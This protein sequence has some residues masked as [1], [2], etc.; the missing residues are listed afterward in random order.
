MCE[1]ER[2]RL[3]ERERN[4]QTDRQTDRQRGRGRDR[5]RHRQRDRE[6]QVIEMLDL[7]LNAFCDRQTDRERQGGWERERDRQTD[8]LTDRLTDTQTLRNHPARAGRQTAE[9]PIRQTTQL[10]TPEMAH[11][12]TVMLVLSFHLVRIRSNTACKPNSTTIKKQTASLPGR[13]SLVPGVWAVCFFSQSRR[14]RRHTEIVKQARPA[15]V[16]SPVYRIV[17]HISMTSYPGFS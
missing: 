15:P 8:R 6:S 3:R 2:E 1:R 14:R 11:E 7:I 9:R 16:P 5:D 10:A 13:V 12:D 17:L 4:R